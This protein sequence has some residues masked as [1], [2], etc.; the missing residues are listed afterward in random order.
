MSVTSE[1][2]LSLL[3]GV[4]LLMIGLL[5]IGKVPVRYNLRNLVVR[6]RT[7][8]MTA[9]AFTLVISLLVVM[10][11]FVNGMYRLTASS[12]RADNVLLLALGAQ[13]E[14]F[15]N[16][17]IADT[18]EIESQAG[19]A[20]VDDKP[21]C[22]KETYLIINQPIEK[23]LPGQPRR[24]FL[25]V[26]GI[27]D[28]EVS[29]EVHDIDLYEGGKWF[30]SAGVEAAEDNPQLSRIQVVLG[31][32][33]ARELGRDPTNRERPA[34]AQRGR[35]DVGDT[36]A[37]ANENWIVVGVMKSAGRTFD[38]EV[39]AKRSLVGPRF[40]K[41]SYSSLLVRAENAQEAVRL[42]ERFAGEYKQAALDAALE[43]EYF[44]KLS[45]TNRQFLGAIIVLAVVMAL[46]GV[47][48]VMNTMFAAISQRIKDI[49][50]LQILGYARWQIL[51]SFLLE[52]L[53]LALVGGLVGCAL[54]WLVDG[55]TATS[56]VG[57]GQGGGK[58]IILKLSVD[59]Q[60]L[61]AGL[62]LTMFM[63]LLGGIVPAISAMRL[64]P[65]DAVR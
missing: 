48:G 31:E 50:V 15:S 25:Q 23:A 52:S 36:F 6:W 14:A 21:L 40:G 56:I 39:W 16:L 8:L 30:S 33:I 22:S 20:R 51:V 17:S 59:A 64:R 32:G 27:E 45:G 44:E 9:L 19:I 3:G 41:P 11:A 61:G 49:G 2:L 55:W 13:D 34:V 5:L 37:L 46:G 28:P 57:S 4:A 62:C 54:G 38:S 47:F 60:V 42:K 53:V 43:T 63:G 18:G 65:L 29:A 35:L 1:T 58:S 24:R 12:G 26:R 7:T 10:L